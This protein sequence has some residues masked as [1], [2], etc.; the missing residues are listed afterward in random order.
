MT[1]KTP[2]EMAIE[3]MNAAIDASW[4]SRPCPTAKLGVAIRALQ[5]LSPQDPDL[6]LPEKPR[7]KQCLTEPSILEPSPQASGESHAHPASMKQHAAPVDAQEGDIDFPTGAIVNGNTLIERLENHYDFECEDGL[8]RNCIEWEGLRRCFDCLVHYAQNTLNLD[9][10]LI[11]GWMIAH[12]I[13]TGHGDTTQDLLAALS[14]HIANAGKMIWQPIETAPKDG[15]LII[16][17]AV[18][19]TETGNWRQEIVSFN[20]YR[21]VGM[22]ESEWFGWPRYMAAPT[23]WMPLPEGP[24]DD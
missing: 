4:Y 17:F 15:K 20:P 6:P 7:L 12:S 11:A 22:G 14:D 21:E 24:K 3:A 23:H 2:I 5:Q 9:R 8:L 19:D 1:T 10:E 13:P 16:V 18:V